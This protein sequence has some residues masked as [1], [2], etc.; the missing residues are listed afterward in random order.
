VN[1]FI[2][3]KNY[4]PTSKVYGS[5]EN[6]Y[7]EDNCVNYFIAKKNYYSGG[8]AKENTK[9]SFKGIGG[10]DVIL[11]DDFDIL[12]YTTKELYDLY[13]K[14]NK[15]DDNLE[16]LFK[17]LYDNKLYNKDK[18]DDEKRYVNLLTFSMR[19]VVNSSKKNIENDS[20]KYIESCCVKGIYNIKKI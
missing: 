15:I 8:G 13:D 5:F 10:R 1:Y 14:G 2:A 12:N 11:A 7:K 16:V 18:H 17:K 19:R 4:S 9:Y 20:D 6:E 3:K